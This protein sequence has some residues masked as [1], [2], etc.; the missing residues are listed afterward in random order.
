[1]SVAEDRRCSAVQRVSWAETGWQE[2]VPFDE[3]AIV[4]TGDGP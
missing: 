1:M 2:E 4:K 3:L